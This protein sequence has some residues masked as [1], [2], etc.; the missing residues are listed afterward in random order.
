MLA[1]SAVQLGVLSDVETQPLTV[2]LLCKQAEGQ[3]LDPTVQRG[4]DGLGGVLGILAVAVAHAVGAVDG[5]DQVDGHLGPFAA[6]ALARRCHLG[7]RGAA[8]DAQR[9]G[10]EVVALGGT[11]QH[12]DVA[13]VALGR[14]AGRVGVLAID[15]P[16]HAGPGIAGQRHVGQARDAGIDADE[17]AEAHRDVRIRQALRGVQLHVL[18]GHALGLHGVVLEQARPREGSRV[19]GVVQVKVRL[20]QEALVEHE[21]CHAQDDREEE[22]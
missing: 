2:R 3:P 1:G 13:D 9:R 5:H 16:G 14:D 19:E 12:D 4:A 21:R 18:A 20:A 22:A 7:V 10:E 17:A 6:E 8:I 11:L 15:R